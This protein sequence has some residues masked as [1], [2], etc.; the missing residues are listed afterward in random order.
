LQ[1]VPG[2]GGGSSG[3]TLGAG[4][5]EAQVKRTL[6]WDSD[7][8]AKADA[9]AGYSNSVHGKKPERAGITVSLTSTIPG[10][11]TLALG[12]RTAADTVFHRFLNAYTITVNRAYFSWA[13]S[14]A[15]YPPENSFSYSLTNPDGAVE[16]GKSGS[17]EHGYNPW[18]SYFEGKYKLTAASP[19]AIFQLLICFDEGSEFADGSNLITSVPFAPSGGTTGGAGGGATGGSGG[20]GGTTGGSSEPSTRDQVVSPELNGRLLGNDG[21]RK[22]FVQ[23]QDALQQYVTYARLNEFYCGSD[24]TIKL[25]PYIGDHLDKD[26]IVLQSG[27]SLFEG[28]IGPVP[29]SGTVTVPSGSLSRYNV[30]NPRRSNSKL[31]L[32]EGSVDIKDFGARDWTAD[33]LTYR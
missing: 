30:Q 20:T 1:P 25:Q 22:E 7:S 8:D 12:G 14:G 32:W 11:T 26:I 19:E 2:Y 21:Q 23:L 31:P 13:P 27:F 15:N 10:S 24:G 17:G 29:S 3:V 5:G 16:T 4:N 28:G 6:C 18:C 9:L 33:Q